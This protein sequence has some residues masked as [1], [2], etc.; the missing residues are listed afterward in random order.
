M[1]SRWG[2]IP[3]CAAL[4]CSIGVNGFQGTVLQMTLEV[5]A[6]APGHHLEL[7]ARNPYNDVLR[8]NG[9]FTDS[10][11]SKTVYP[12]GLQVQQAISLDDPCMIDDKGNLLTTAAAYPSSV[13]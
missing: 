10:A 7:W 9:S 12:Y 3:L 2:V 5:S 4:G 8:I 11:T 6:S 13:F 1:V